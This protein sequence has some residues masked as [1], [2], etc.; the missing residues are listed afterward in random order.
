M[1]TC[2]ASCPDAVVEAILLRLLSFYEG[3]KPIEEVMLDF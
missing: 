3:T 1:L 2:G